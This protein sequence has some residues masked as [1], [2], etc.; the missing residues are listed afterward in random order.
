MIGLVIFWMAIVLWFASLVLDSY[1][2]LFVVNRDMT[3]WPIVLT[4]TP[5]VDTIFLIVLCIKFLPKDFFG[6]DKLTDAFKKQ[7]G[8]N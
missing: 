1:L 8:K 2:W 7:D 5:V 4:F 6:L 3:F